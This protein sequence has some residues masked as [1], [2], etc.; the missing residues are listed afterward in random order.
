MSAFRTLS[1]ALVV[2]ALAACGAEPPAEEA[3]QA[4]APAAVETAAAPSPCYIAGGTPEEALTRPSP[5]SEAAFAAGGA[6][7]TICYGAPSV[8]GRTIMG[9]LVPFGEPWRLGANEAT[10]L[11][12]STAAMVGGVHVEP[13][14]YSLYAVPTATEWTFYLNSN[15]QRWGI[16]IDDAV[17][18]TEVG[19][20]TTA[21]EATAAPVE[22]LRFTFEPAADGSGGDLVMEWESTRVRFPISSMHAPMDD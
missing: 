6:K 2:A 5:L 15:V 10:A 16:P 21:A 18:A 22:T 8:K 7:G 4:E 9:E 19:S 14:S 12:L 20:F 13:G 1:A 11:H 17:R 3:A